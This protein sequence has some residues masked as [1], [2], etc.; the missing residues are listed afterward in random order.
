VV[1][2]REQ[3]RKISGRLVPRSKLGRRAVLEIAAPAA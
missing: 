1:E 3:M 2:D